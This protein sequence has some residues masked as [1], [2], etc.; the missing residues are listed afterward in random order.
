MTELT[1]EFWKGMALGLKDELI[2]RGNR[3]AELELLRGEMALVEIDNARLVAKL[4]YSV[5]L[6]DIAW[7]I[8]RY[9]FLIERGQDAALDRVNDWLDIVKPR[10]EMKDNER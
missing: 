7:V 3:M 9:T 10:E 2:E 1:L 8:A 4:A 6:D 5:P